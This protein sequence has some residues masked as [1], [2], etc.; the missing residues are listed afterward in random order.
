[1]RAGWTQVKGRNDCLEDRE[2]T[3]FRRIA[4]GFGG[5]A[6]VFRLM[7]ECEYHPGICSDD[8]SRHV[9]DLTGRS[10]NHFI[11]AY[12]RQYIFHWPFRTSSGIMP[13]VGQVTRTATL[14]RGVLTPARKGGTRFQLCGTQIALPSSAKSAFCI[15]RWF[16]TADGGPVTSPRCAFASG[17]VTKRRPAFSVWDKGPSPCGSP[18]RLGIAGA[19]GF[20]SD[21][22]HRRCGPESGSALRIMTYIMVIVPGRHEEIQRV[23]LH[24]DSTVV[25]NVQDGRGSRVVQ[26]RS[27]ASSSIKPRVGFTAALIWQFAE[28]LSILGVT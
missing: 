6:K 13:C 19:S 26:P 4:N 2:P 22:V 27:P 20:E 24:R 9:R 14:C 17:G 8:T 1:M 7:A 18:V 12:G 25:E 11:D 28:L 21:A 5:P 3:T 15:S 16:N 23:I 10:P